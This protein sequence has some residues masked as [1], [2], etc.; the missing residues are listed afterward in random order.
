[1]KGEL[2]ILRTYGGQPL[3]RRVFE[4]TDKAVF[5]TDDAR[6]D[7][8]ISVGIPRDDVFE[9]DPNLAANADQLFKSGKWDWKKLKPFK[10]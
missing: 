2:V 5:V 8:L 6:K 4:I 1:M 10:V 7:G 3:V 9:Y